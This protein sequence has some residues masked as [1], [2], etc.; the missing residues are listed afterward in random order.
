MII[1]K[2]QSH[3]YYNTCSTYERNLA[4]ENNN[5]GAIIDTLEGEAKKDKKIEPRAN[6]YIRF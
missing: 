1:K 2:L 6:S 5:D 4:L 3:C